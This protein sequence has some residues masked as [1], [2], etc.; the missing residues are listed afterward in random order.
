MITGNSKLRKYTTIY[1][2]SIYTINS[3]EDYTQYGFKLLKQSNNKK[4]GK[5]VKKGIYKNKPLYSLSLVER[6][7]GCRKHCLH[8]QD[9]YG[10]NMPFAHR[11]KTDNDMIFCNILNTEIFN[12]L[13][14]HK[15]GIHIR[16]H[17]LGD[18]FSSY[19]INWWL[20]LLTCYENVSVYG[21]TAHTKHSVLGSKIENTIRKIGFNRF[22]VR[23]SNSN[24]KLSANS[25]EFSK[26]KVVPINKN[27]SL[28]SIPCP[29][30]INKVENC[31]SC[32]LCWNKNVNQI[33]F[34]TH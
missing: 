30:Q 33:S 9:C 28:K 11:F 14:K 6:E 34:K 10:I 12:L 5:V 1:P 26:N 7:M 16:L 3:L 19:Y 25:V 13:K 8:W 29:E 20:A 15:Q 17:V 32:A 31:S 18:F 24:V 23:Y 21:Y 2:K 27:V 4:L 22:A